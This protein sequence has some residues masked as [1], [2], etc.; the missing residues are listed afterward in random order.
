MSPLLLPALPHLSAK[1]ACMLSSPGLAA[2]Q[3]CVNLGQHNSIT[4]CSYS[5]VHALLDDVLSFLS[6]DHVVSSSISLP[7]SYVY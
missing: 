2:C 5:L 1:D 6:G 7:A 3:I 4:H